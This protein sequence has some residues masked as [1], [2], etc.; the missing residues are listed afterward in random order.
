MHSVRVTADVR[1]VRD[2]EPKPWGYAACEASRCAVQ[3]LGELYEEDYQKA[4]GFAAEDAD[5]PLRQEVRLHPSCPAE[6]T[7]VAMNRPNLKLSC[8]TNETYECRQDHSA[9]S[10]VPMSNETDCRAAAAVVRSLIATALAP[11]ARKAGFA[12]CRCARR[13]GGWPRSWTR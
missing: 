7:S 9:C 4:A 12:C 13:C 2:F 10:T 1:W 8:D 3:G 11:C 6:V 5:E